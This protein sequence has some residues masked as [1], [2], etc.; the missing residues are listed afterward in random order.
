MDHRKG[1]DGSGAAG[2]LPPARNIQPDQTI[3]VDSEAVRKYQQ[4]AFKGSLLVIAGSAA[5]IGTHVLVEG[6]VPIGREPSGLQ[7]SDARI[8]RNHAA[9]EQ[10]ESGYLLHDLGSTNGTSLNGLPVSGDA[11][12]QDGDR[13]LVGQTV[14][15]FTMVDETEASYLRRIQKLAGT[16]ELTGLMAKH[17]FDS[18]LQQAVKTARASGVP[19]SVLMMD[20]DGLKAINDR[21]GHQM[22]ASTISQVG[23]MLG[24]VMAGRGEACR[25]GGDE[26]SAFL[27]GTPRSEALQ[28]AERIR[29]QVEQAAFTHN[30]I[31]V[32]ITISIGVAELT[33]TMETGGELLAVADQAL[34]RAKAKGRNTIS[35]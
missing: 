14:I 7:L 18:L 31:A 2:P 28:V 16:D 8:S 30:Q 34:Y 32:K 23:A 35:D 10:G 12:L 1:G 5:D 15:K 4:S 20:M 17:R 29:N 13:I 24:Q 3:R 19:L 33:S 27:L 22:G 25:F 26:F 11:R 21:H 6:T 9:V